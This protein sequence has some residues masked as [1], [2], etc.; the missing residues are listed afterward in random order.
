MSKAVNLHVDIEAIHKAQC[1]CDE[2]H[3]GTTVPVDAAL[4]SEITALV[5][6]EVKDL[7]EESWMVEHAP[8]FERI[9]AY[10]MGK[11]WDVAVGSTPDKSVILKENVKTSLGVWDAPNLR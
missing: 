9:T 10:K 5:N 7:S 4:P 1:S 6:G 11:R 3:V 2:C 8:G